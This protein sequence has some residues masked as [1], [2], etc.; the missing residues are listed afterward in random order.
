MGFQEP[1]I[2]GPVK[3]GDP[4]IQGIAKVAGAGSEPATLV[5]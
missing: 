5:D 4:A 3:H 1:K 2:A